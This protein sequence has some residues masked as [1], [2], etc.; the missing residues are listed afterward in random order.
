M[1]GEERPRVLAMGMAQ[2]MA[3]RAARAQAHRQRIGIVAIVALFAVPL[4]VLAAWLPGVVAAHTGGRAYV[5]RIALPD[6]SAPIGL[7]PVD[8]PADGSRPLVVIDAGHGGHDPGASG[9]GTEREKGLTLALA[10]ALRDA[11][12]ADGRV[13]VALTRSDDRFLVLQERAGIAR[14]LHAD[15]FLSIH[16]DAVEGGAGGASGATLYTLSDKGSDALADAVA[17][18]ENRVDTVNGVALGGKDTAVSQFL[19]DLSQQRMRASSQA[20]AAL[21]RREGQGHIRFRDVPVQQAAF[22]VL[23]SLDV[24][25]VLLEAGYV[26]SPEDVQNMRSRPW[27]DGFGRAVARAIEIVLANQSTAALPAAGL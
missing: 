14:R 21:I 5:V 1:I 24:P 18:R 17:A 11:L 13:R 10:L 6:G 12:I 22:V 15:L 7:P 20:F 26:S 23:K 9:A 3:G 27:R 16:A 4:L 25:S 8:G 2:E 19:V